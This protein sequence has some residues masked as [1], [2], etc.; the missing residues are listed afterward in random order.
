MLIIRNISLFP[1]T[2][3]FYQVFSLDLR[4]GN[5]ARD[6]KLQLSAHRMTLI[7]VGLCHVEG[8][9][10]CSNPVSMVIC[11]LLSFSLLWTVE[12]VQFQLNKL[13]VPISCWHRSPS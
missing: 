13:K 7:S 9:A 12:N 1:P 11:F 2:C 4:L 10:V 8:S 3:S 5:D 6:E